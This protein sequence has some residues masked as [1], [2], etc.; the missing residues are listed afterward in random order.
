MS[1]ITW[2]FIF[3]STFSFI[4][5]LWKNFDKQ[6]TNATWVQKHISEVWNLWA[7][8]SIVPHNSGGELPVS[9]MG[10]VTL[11]LTFI[12]YIFLL[13]RKQYESFPIF[14][15]FPIFKNILLCVPECW[16]FILSLFYFFFYS[17][18]S[19]MLINFKYFS[20]FFACCVWALLFVLS[21]Y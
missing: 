19:K 9:Y 16:F 11:G 7:M 17:L 3:S 14:H 4:I 13:L 10:C 8:L 5:S 12:P 6:Y 1:S 2:L 15:F 20:L 18:V 21:F